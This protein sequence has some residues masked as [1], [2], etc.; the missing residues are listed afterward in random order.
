L[1]FSM[2]TYPNYIKPGVQSG[3][4][5]KECRESP[6]KRRGATVPRHDQLLDKWFT[7]NR[8]Q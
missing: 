6:G 5:L 8:E 7:Q 4:L 3:I 1:K 2:T